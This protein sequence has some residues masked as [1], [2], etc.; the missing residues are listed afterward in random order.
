MTVL[1]PQDYLNDGNLHNTVVAGLVI[2]NNDPDG[3]QRIKCRVSVLHQGIEDDDLPWCRPIK[4]E[5]QG[6]MNIGVPRIGE[7]AALQYNTEDDNHNI[8]YLGVFVLNG[9]LPAI[10]QSIFPNC[11]GFVDSAGNVFIVNT[12]TNTISLIHVT[13][14]FVEITASTI[15]V[16]S[17][18]T[19]L[20]KAAGNVAISAGGNIDLDGGTIN[21]NGGDNPAA[22]LESQPQPAPPAPP[23]VSDLTDY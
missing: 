17:L 12:A 20:I 3:G 11:Y 15:N 10:F 22:S 2:D 9:T 4:N 14:A 18:G 13:G 19:L 21:L 16:L 6:V 1:N 23:N 5:M 7:I 8:Y